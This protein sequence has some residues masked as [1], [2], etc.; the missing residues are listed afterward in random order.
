MSILRIHTH[1]N[2]FQACIMIIKYLNL[3]Y[4]KDVNTKKI[5]VLVFGDSQLYIYANNK[6]FNIVM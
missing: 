6:S 3:E 4:F 5:T 1:M 2:K